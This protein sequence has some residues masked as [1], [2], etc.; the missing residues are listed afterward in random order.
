MSGLF[1]TNRIRRDAR[2][3]KIAA[4]E[5]IPV[6]WAMQKAR[7]R[8]PEEYEAAFNKRGEAQAEIAKAAERPPGREPSQFMAL[9]REL[10]IQKNL[11]G[12]EALREARRLNPEAFEAYRSK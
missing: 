5:D 1:S 6:T 8:F 2:V 3:A 4:D 11:S 9:A 7:Q 12:E 10:Q